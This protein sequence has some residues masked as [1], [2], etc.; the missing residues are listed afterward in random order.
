[1]VVTTHHLLE[2]PLSVNVCNES[3]GI[4][5]SIVP[6]WTSQVSQIPQTS[7]S[8][9]G[10]F[11]HHW[12]V[13]LGDNAQVASFL[14]KSGTSRW[15]CQSN[16][17]MSKETIYKTCNVVEVDVIGSLV[18]SGWECWQISHDA[19]RVRMSMLISGWNPPLQAQGWCFI[20][21][22]YPAWI[23]SGIA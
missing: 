22:W 6:I 12:T 9:W 1:M 19:S 7:L 18:T 2:L 14:L 17:N 21:P 10:L 23:D 5:L 15:P 20:T 11:L 4:L 8:V 13:P 3:T 16:V